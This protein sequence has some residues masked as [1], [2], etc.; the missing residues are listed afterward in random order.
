LLTKKITLFHFSALQLYGGNPSTVDHYLTMTASSLPS[1]F[2]LTINLIPLPF[3]PTMEM[4]SSD[5]S[6]AQV[7]TT[8]LTG[9]STP[10]EI[11]RR[12]AVRSQKD[13][14]ITKVPVPYT[15]ELL[16]V[17]VPDYICG[18]L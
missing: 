15:P 4:S 1:S 3:T 12:V 5:F 9:S 10:I 18:L 2:L 16:Q 6:I 11:L 8:G 14:T 7:N 13:V 17:Y